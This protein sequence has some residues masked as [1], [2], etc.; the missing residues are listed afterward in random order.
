M[1]FA[2][3]HGLGNSYVYIDLVTQPEPPVDWPTLA[4]R[5]SD[6]GFGVGSDG[7][8]LILPSQRADLRMRMF[9][10]DGSEG[11]MCGN[12]IRCL[13]RYAADTGLIKR[14]RLRVETLAGIRDL[15]LIRRGDTVSAVRVDMGKPR[16]KPS[17]IPI[18]W[19][20]VAASGRG[21]SA[22]PTDDGPVLDA[23]LC[24]DDEVHRVTAVSMGNP[25]C[26]LLVDDV[27]EAPV[28]SLG[29]RLE[30]H[31]AFPHG[32]NVEFIQVVDPDHL[33]MRVWERGSG[34]TYAC[35][36]G[37][38]AAAVATHLLNLTGRRVTVHMLGG[39][40][41]IEWKPDG[42]V[43]MSGPCETICTGELSEEWLRSGSGNE[44]SAR[45]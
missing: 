4:R 38:C 29:P 6:P 26:V 41:D 20:A 30:H 16:L 13:A 40:L 15:E 3:L 24:V 7:L 23:P 8:I 27:D 14:D 21:D 10:A 31:P 22:Q 19:A 2:K 32:V 5:V 36:T 17:E 12:G 18:S 11:E 25:H 44:R 39:D 45:S 42:H 35:G 33:R 37:A 9:N 28:R 1:R 43:Y 34:E